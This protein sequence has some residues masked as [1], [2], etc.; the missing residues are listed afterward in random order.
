MPIT[1][2]HKF[3]LDLIALT[4]GKVNS[5]HAK[6]KNNSTMIA[7]LITLKF[8]YSFTPF[9][10]INLWLETTMRIACVR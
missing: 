7:D 4:L 2:Q 6:G 9:H 3:M 8:C 1:R 5:V 10:L